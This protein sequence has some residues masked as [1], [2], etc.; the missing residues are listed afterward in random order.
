MSAPQ[1]RAQTGFARA[2]PDKIFLIFLQCG[3]FSPGAGA[4]G[5]CPPMMKGIHTEP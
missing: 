4:N 3:T 5:M 1:S 2:G